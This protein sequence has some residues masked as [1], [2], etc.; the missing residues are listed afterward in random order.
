[1]TARLLI[2]VLITTVSLVHTQNNDSIVQ[3]NS[4]LKDTIIDGQSRVIKT[5]NPIEDSIGRQGF[6]DHKIAA[7][8]EARWLRELYSTSLYDTI[9]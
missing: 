6:K 2:I 8:M 3:N 7:E 9:Y 1:M 4:I 5:I